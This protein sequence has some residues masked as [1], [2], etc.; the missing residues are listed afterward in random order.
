M[1][2]Q[3]VRQVS[4]PRPYSAF[5]AGLKL[6]STSQKRATRCFGGGYRQ[7]LAVPKASGLSQPGNGARMM[8]DLDSIAAML[9]F[10]RTIALLVGA[11]L[12]FLGYKLFKIGYFEKAGELQAVWGN[13][14]F[15]LKQVAPGV[16]FALFGTVILCVGIWKPISVNRSESDSPA[17]IASILQPVRTVLQKVADN[18]DLTDAERGSIRNWLQLHAEERQERPRRSY[19]AQQGTAGLELRP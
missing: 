6:T 9:I 7:R 11:M 1:R 8:E 19:E 16:F 17:S 18:Q 13:R 3:G 12:L 14:Q 10:F 4:P 2:G 15:I 5:N